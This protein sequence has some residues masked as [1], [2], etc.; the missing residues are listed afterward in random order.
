MNEIKIPSW[1]DVLA[2]IRPFGFC[3]RCVAKFKEGKPVLVLKSW[4]IV[5]RWAQSRCIACGGKLETNVKNG[6]KED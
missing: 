4:H 1:V 2:R 6:V 3:E 5:I